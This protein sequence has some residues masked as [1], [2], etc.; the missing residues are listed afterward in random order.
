MLK[1][2]IYYIKHCDRVSRKIDLTQV[3]LINIRALTSQRDLE[4]ATKDNKTADPPSVN[5]R[6]MPKTM[7]NIK[8]WCIKIRGVTGAPLAYM[9][10]VALMPEDEDD[11]LSQ[12]YDSV[13]GEM[14][15]RAPIIDLS[16]DYD[17]DNESDEDLEATGPFT[18]SFQIDRVALYHKL[19][20]VFGQIE[21]WTH[22]KTTGRLKCGRKVWK[23]LWNH[24]LGPNNVHHIATQATARLR[25]ISYTGEKKQHNFA[26]YCTQQVEEH[27][28]IASL[29]PYGQNTL[30]EREKVA[31]L[32]EGVKCEKLKVVKCQIMATDAATRT[33]IASA[34]QFADYITTL[35]ID[36]PR[37]LSEVATERNPKKVPW[38]R[39]GR[40]D[41]AGRGGGG[42]TRLWTEAGVAKAQ[43][44]NKQFPPR[45]CAKLTPD[46][47]QKL[48]RLQRDS[49]S[50]TNKTNANLARI[51]AL[52]TKF[53]GQEK[54]S[55]EENL[56]ATS[57][58]ESN[59][60]NPA[61]ARQHKKAKKGG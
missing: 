10:R 18:T 34:R 31:Y 1:I 57:S 23:L 30:T 47:K 46:Q 45:E 7:E 32:L 12:D 40:G 51:A 39:G 13:D 4:R 21:C 2:I 3:E 53:K 16:F 58:D 22:A 43:V 8:E 49:K 44:A 42:G 52:E 33:Y 35:Y 9:M 14:I 38:A 48:F 25:T 17:P 36:D 55:D 26:T 5:L 28:T 19:H 50:A 29:V 59:F 6:S 56:F 37:A 24:Y 41:R 27:N 20:E 11:A 60:N 61:L 54:N 15:E